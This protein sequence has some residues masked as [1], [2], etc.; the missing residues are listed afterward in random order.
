[1]LALAPLAV[2]CTPSPWPWSLST[3]LAQPSFAHFQMPPWSMPRSS[4]ASVQRCMAGV[5]LAVAS[6]DFTC[7]WRTV[8]AARHALLLASTLLRSSL[9][10]SAVASVDLELPTADQ[11]A[12]SMV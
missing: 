11:V 1:M 7:L 9:L 12:R 8:S 10:A 5:G 2:G 4:S 3:S 6:Q